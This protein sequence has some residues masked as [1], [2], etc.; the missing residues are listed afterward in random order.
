MFV[1][2]VE[3]RSAEDYEVGAFYSK[4]KL[5][6]NA[7]SVFGVVVKRVSRGYAKNGKSIP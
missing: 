3:N 2:D 7:N 1:V 4:I 5:F 6:E